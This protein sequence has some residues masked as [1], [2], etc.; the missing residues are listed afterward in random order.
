MCSAREGLRLDSD[1]IGDSITLEYK[2]K[3][4]L[5]ERVVGDLS[6]LRR[7]HRDLRNG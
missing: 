2:L 6:E 5:V 4:L 1:E 7:Y 3:K